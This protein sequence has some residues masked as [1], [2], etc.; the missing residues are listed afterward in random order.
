MALFRSRSHATNKCIEFLHVEK[1]KNNVDLLLEVLQRLE[2]VLS[3][4]NSC[5]KEYIKLGVISKVVVIFLF[6][7]CVCE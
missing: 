3:K 6:F 7:G 5:V 4:G 2:E 1:K